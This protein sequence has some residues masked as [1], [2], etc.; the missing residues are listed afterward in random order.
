MTVESP[1]SLVPDAV[2]G[3]RGSV[4]NGVLLH[5]DNKH[6]IY[7]LGS[8]VV[9]RNLFDRSQSFLTGHDKHITCIAVSPCGR[10]IASGQKH[11]HGFTADIILWDFSARA[12]RNRL[13]VHKGE[14]S[15]V[16]FSHDSE[17][18]ASLGGQDDNGLIVWSVG[19][20]I[21]VCG[22]PAGQ[23]TATCVS[24]F[25]RSS[26][27][28]MTGG[29]THLRMWCFDDRRLSP[30]SVSTGT[31]KRVT[32]AICLSADDKVAYCGTSSGDI[33]EINVE[34][35]AYVRMGPVKS[36]FGQG[37][38][39]MSALPGG[40][41]L[42]GSGDGTISRVS[43][44]S[45][46][47]QRECK[48]LGRVT[49]LAITNDGTHGFCATEQCNMYWLNSD[50]VTAEVRNSCHSE[51]INTVFFPF[52]CS[53]VFATI[54]AN[55]IR[56]WN[57]KTRLEVL[58]IQIPG[59]ECY[60]GVFS[61]D[62]KSIV[63]G[64]SDGKIR[65]FTPQTGKLIYI[66]NDAHKNG[67]T[68]IAETTDGARLVSGGAEGE[69]RIWRVSKGAA[70]MEISLKEHRGKVT[71]LEIS[72]DNQRA[73]S[74]SSDGTV[75]TWDLIA[76]VR[77][78]AIFEPTMFKS[79]VYSADEAQL[80]TTGSDRKITFWDCYDAEAIRVLEGSREGEVTCLAISQSGSHFA[81]AGADGV[82]RVW[83]YD[84]GICKFEGLGHTGIV[85]ALAFSPDQKTLV[86]VGTEG[87]IFVWNLPEKVTSRCFDSSN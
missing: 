16:S 77:L 19:K 29:H 54:A 51:R 86:S 13:S 84:L 76:K 60:S 27:H 64:W 41:L 39:A 36:R 75:I 48:V 33:L 8:T 43:P 80:V 42:V 56:V 18:L 72:K 73:V 24:F 71:H 35:A 11:Y 17:F 14:V 10:Y 57:A 2:I 49:S 47:V 74:S 4:S 45:M 12:L 20:G 6:L 25:N 50:S 5:P 78:L 53:D 32:T 44:G 22:S 58:R 66:I 26:R 9:V 85:S 82:V 63:T 69:V 15:C 28:L 37:V 21:P 65:A 31:I 23:E 1:E 38:S 67:V 70:S 7:V 52:G 46:R 34:R 55:D 62:G 3:F 30:T 81:S 87:A 59:V 83:D 79:A 61:R 68:S 40:D